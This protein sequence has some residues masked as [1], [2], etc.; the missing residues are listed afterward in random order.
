M[1]ATGRQAE[2]ENEKE[3]DIDSAHNSR[4]TMVLQRS[5]LVADY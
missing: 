3:A 1:I 4:P 5:Q 2:K